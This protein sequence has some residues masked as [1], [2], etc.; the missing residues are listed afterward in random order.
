MK[1]IGRSGNLSMDEGAL[2]GYGSNGT[3][4]FKGLWDGHQVAV[5]RM[6]IAFV[7]MVDAEMKVLLDLGADWHPNL[8]RYYGKDEDENFVFLA[9]DLCATTMHSRVEDATFN[10]F[11]QDC[12]PLC[13]RPSP[14]CLC[15]SMV[16]SMAAVS[17]WRRLCERGVHANAA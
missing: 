14:L 13:L 2:L 17:S 7:E 6:H 16:L 8:L 3:M 4:V 11:L 5:K 15:R 12:T 10:P 1:P 9:S